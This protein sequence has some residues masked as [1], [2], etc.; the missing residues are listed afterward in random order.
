MKCLH[1]LSSFQD[2]RNEKEKIRKQTSKIKVLCYISLKVK[3]SKFGKNKK[4][5]QQ[6]IYKINK[7]GCPNKKGPNFFQKKKISG[8]DVYSGPKSRV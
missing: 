6:K 8:G 4:F 7:R 2:I 3:P 5:S 1:I